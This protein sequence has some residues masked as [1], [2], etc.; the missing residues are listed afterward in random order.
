MH[1]VS[2]DRSVTF[3]LHGGNRIPRAADRQAKTVADLRAAGIGIRRVLL[4]HDGTPSG[5]DVFEWMITMI[6][7]DVHL[8]LV[9]ATVEGTLP[10]GDRDPVHLD[11]QRAAQLGRSV[12][13]LAEQPQS[14][15]EIVRLA[16]EGNYDVLVLPWPD[17]DWTPATAA[18]DE[19]V[20][21]VRHHAPCSVFL[22]AHPVI[23][24]EV[25]AT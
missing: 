14:G 19:W 5:H 23:Q 7:P 1:I 18:A 3:D 10:A 15:P 16:R 4:V 11:Q 25:V 9:P 13:L 8:D 20:N 24:R 12:Q 2:A 21:Y 17:A 6:A 22:A